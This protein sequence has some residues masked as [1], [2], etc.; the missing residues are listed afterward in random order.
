MWTISVFKLILLQQHH[1]QLH[2]LALPSTSLV[3]YTL[4]QLCTHTSFSIHF[5]W[6]TFLSILSLSTTTSR[7]AWTVVEGEGT[8]WIGGPALLCPPIGRT[9]NLQPETQDWLHT[10]S[11][12]VV[13]QTQTCLY[14]KGCLPK[15]RALVEHAV[16]VLLCGCSFPVGEDIAIWIIHPPCAWDGYCSIVWVLGHGCCLRGDRC[17][18]REIEWMVTFVWHPA[19]HFGSKKWC[20]NTPGSNG[21]E[22][23]SPDL[24]LLTIKVTYII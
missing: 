15:S 18:E 24:L 4:Q 6:S 17:R 11:H 1:I 20:Q 13:K 14:I 22:E 16:K 10:V 23:T 3:L 5:R 21:R 12:S 8:T 2:T 9:G 19:K 7:T